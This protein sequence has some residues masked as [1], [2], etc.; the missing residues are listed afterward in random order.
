MTDA[1]A[2]SC[3]GERPVAEIELPNVKLNTVLALVAA[4]VSTF[5]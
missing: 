2:I 3:D 1:G 5:C 4:I